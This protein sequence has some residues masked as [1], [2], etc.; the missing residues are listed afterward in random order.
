MLHARHTAHIHAKTTMHWF[1][2]QQGRLTSCPND[3]ST[4]GIRLAHIACPHAT[5]FEAFLRAGT[6]RYLVS[7]LNG[8]FRIQSDYVTTCIHAY[9]MKQNLAF[10][11]RFMHERCPC[12]AAFMHSL[13]ST[14]PRTCKMCCS[15]SDERKQLLGT[16]KAPQYLVSPRNGRNIRSS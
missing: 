12:S 13:S 9:Q 14:E 10:F 1:E 15:L 8:S 3:A 11:K 6:G 7:A 2:R 16:V 5:D 4:A